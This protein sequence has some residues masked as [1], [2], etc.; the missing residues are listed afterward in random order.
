MSRIAD[1]G[2]DRVDRPVSSVRESRCLVGERWLK[3]GDA[4]V[5][6]I[7][8]YTLRMALTMSFRSSSVNLGSMITPPR[9]S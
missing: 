7:A 9:R 1:A 4:H 8:K 2:Q 5:A 3:G 6:Y